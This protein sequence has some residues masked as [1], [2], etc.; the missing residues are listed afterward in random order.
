M[1]GLGR[2]RV[3]SLT[4]VGALAT[5]LRLRLFL[6][7]AER[8]VLRCGRLLR[9]TRRSL[10]GTFLAL[11]DLSCCSCSSFR[12]IFGAGELGLTGACGVGVL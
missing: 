8:S 2:Y 9:R 4:V 5:L 7:F 11:A 12:G 1:S 3:E 10:L 6:C